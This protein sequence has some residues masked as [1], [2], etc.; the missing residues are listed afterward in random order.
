MRARSSVKWTALTGVTPGRIGSSVK[1]AVTRT[2]ND[3]AALKPS[4]SVAVTSIVALPPPTAVRVT[5]GPATRTVT[6]CSTEE[7]AL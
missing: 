6:T 7:V 1:G 3:C 5:R 2:R 4:G